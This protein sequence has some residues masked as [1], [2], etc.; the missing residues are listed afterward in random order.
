MRVAAVNTPVID[1][2]THV[3][4]WGLN[5]MDASPERFLR[6]MDAA[7]IDKACVNCIFY[8]EAR[9]SNDTVARYVPGQLRPLRAGGIR[10]PSIP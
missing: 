8:G 5:H 10:H 2:H 3:G 1:F 7:G 6:L 4:R 9:R